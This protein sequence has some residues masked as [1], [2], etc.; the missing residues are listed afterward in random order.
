MFTFSSF[1][2]DCRTGLIGCCCCMSV[3]THLRP[4]VTGMAAHTSGEALSSQVLDHGY[5]LPCVSVIIPCHNAA[6]TVDSCVQ[7]AM[8]Q[9]YPGLIEICVYDDH[10][11][12]NT[13]EL[14]R[15]WE[16]RMATRANRKVTITTSAQAGLGR[17]FGPSFARN[18]AAESSTGEYLCILDSDDE[19]LPHR[20]SSQLYVMDGYDVQFVSLL[21]AVPCAVNWLQPHR[22]HW[23][24]VDF[25]EFLKA[26]LLAILSG[27]TLSRMMICCC[28]NGAS[29]PSSS[30]H[31]SYHEPLLIESAAGMK[32]CLPP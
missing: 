28:S 15:R 1:I 26:Q 8:D 21:T 16:T 18:R 24:E 14:L 29:A 23:L 25:S 3:V 4:T 12:D 6:K 10:S 31:G 13:V 7:S 20:I 5:R 27:P 22:T 30:R 2:G 11:E 19:M 32:H 17:A 9:E